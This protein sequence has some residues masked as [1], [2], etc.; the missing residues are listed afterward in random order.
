M[1]AIPLLG[2][3]AYVLLDGYA[4]GIL[5]KLFRQYVPPKEQELIN[6]ALHKALPICY[7]LF[8]ISVARYAG[9]EYLA[10]GLLV[11]IGLFDPV[12]NW[13]KRDPLFAVGSSA[14]LDKLLRRLSPTSEGRVASATLRAGALMGVVATLLLVNL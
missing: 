13:A 11:R 6:L 3:I 8:V 9:G 4:Q 10:I 1:E 2:I 5:T 12:L 7:A 14:T